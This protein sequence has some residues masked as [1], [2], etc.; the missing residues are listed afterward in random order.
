V[1]ARDAPNGTA[2][3]DLPVGKL[4]VRAADTR[5]VILDRS[6]RSLVPDG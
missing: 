5:D 6:R 2:T 1:E 3:L 4:A